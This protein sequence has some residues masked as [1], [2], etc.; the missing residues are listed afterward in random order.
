MSPAH[1][2]GLCPRP[3]A[4][5]APSRDRRPSVLLLRD[6]GSLRAPRKP[7]GAS[8]LGGRPLV[9]IRGSYVTPIVGVFPDLLW[10]DGLLPHLPT[11]ASVSPVA[12]PP[13]VI[14]RP[15]SPTEHFWAPRPSQSQP[16]RSGALRGG[17]LARS[18]HSPSG[19]KAWQA[20]PPRAAKVVPSG[21]GRGAVL[22][23]S[24]VTQAWR[25]GWRTEGL[26]SRLSSPR[27]RE[28]REHPACSWGPPT[29]PLTS[30]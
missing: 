3:P 27:H 23:D 6:P 19:T 24:A 11:P 18:E 17:L 2:T 8:G 29:G 15:L 4:A 5:L 30:A 20:A 12:Q 9:V 26:R 13:H 1:G 14:T 22:P 21:A 10:R 25:G 7:G 28:L 16:R